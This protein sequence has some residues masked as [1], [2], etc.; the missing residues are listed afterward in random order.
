MATIETHFD[1][2]TDAELLNAFNRKRDQDAFRTLVERHHSM[3]FG[4]AKKYI[5]LTD[6]LK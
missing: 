6:L 3:V 4:V 5:L 2:Q 1:T